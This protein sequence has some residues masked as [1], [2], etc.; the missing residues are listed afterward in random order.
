M[1]ATFLLATEEET[2]PAEGSCL[3]MSLHEEHLKLVARHRAA[4]VP[5]V[6]LGDFTFKVTVDLRWP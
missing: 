5:L 2:T 3:F 4:G 6:V 1:P